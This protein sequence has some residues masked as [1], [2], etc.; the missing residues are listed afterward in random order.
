MTAASATSR[1]TQVPP[2]SSR[3]ATAAQL[4]RAQRVGLGILG[5]GSLI[6]L[7]QLGAS[8]GVIP[9]SA[10]PGPA[11]VAG[12][13]PGVL[14]SGEFLGA[15][16]DTLLTWLIA[17]AL[18]SAA[19]IVIGLVTSSIPFLRRPSMV[20][21]NVARAVPATALLPIAIL[22]FGLATEMKVA[23]AFWAILWPIIINTSYGVLGTEPLRLDAARSMR[24][25]WWRRQVYVTLPSALPSILTGVRVA[26][27]TAL[28]VV[29]AAELLGARSGVGT[30]LRLYQQA[31]RPDI[32]YAAVIVVGLLGALLYTVLVRLERRAVGWRA[33]A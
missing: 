3:A 21:V 29:I 28:V 14:T 15:L 2:G 10:L 5:T 23:I 20:V 19:G 12:A 24:W 11:V 7:W 31:L 22:M 17:L 13:L 8:T 9:P 6:A 30:F 1:R 33:S 27:G 25:P 16:G 32:V 4:N 26:T 18:G